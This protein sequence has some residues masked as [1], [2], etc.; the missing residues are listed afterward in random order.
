MPKSLRTRLLCW[1]TAILACVI[2]VFGVVVC[3]AAWSSGVAAIDAALRVRAAALAESLRPVGPGTFDLELPPSPPAGEAAGPETYHILWTESGQVI[4]RSDPDLRVPATPPEPAAT[5]QGRREVALATPHGA[6]VLV[7]HDLEALRAEVWSLAGTLAGAGIAALMVALAG[8]WWLVGRAIGPLDRM[9]AT[10]RAMIDGDFTARIP[11][12]RLETELGQVAGALNAAFDR[13]HASLEQQRRFTADASHELR[14]PLAAFT[15]EVEWALRRDRTAVEYR[16]ALV[17]AHRSATRMRHVVESLLML[18]RADAGEETLARI[19]V[20]LDDVVRDTVADLQP[21]AGSRRLTVTVA[22]E[23]AAVIGDPLRLR[24]AVSNLMVNAIKYNTD[25]GAVDVSL[26]RDRTWVE[27]RVSDTGIGIAPAD[28]PHVFDRFYRAD[29]ARQ[30][31]GA[32]L[33]LA[34]TKWIVESH[35]GAIACHSEPGRGTEVVVRL[36][37]AS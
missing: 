7:G 11:I 16:D 29:P 4:D 8:G 18:A 32:G 10:A 12:D 6:T 1:Y 34:V 28:L 20:A 17:V 15:I 5:R 21:L 25:A 2:A 26:R 22:A 33:G 37:A 19:P 24:E 9:N 35:R 30:A 14:T 13:L 3:Y 23:P 27:L 36:P 31:G